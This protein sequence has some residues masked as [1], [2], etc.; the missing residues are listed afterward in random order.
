L[1]SNQSTIGIIGSGSFG[2]TMAKLLSKNVNVLLYS[3]KH[4]TIADLNAHHAHL[5]CDLSE[6]IQLTSDKEELCTKCNIIFPVVPSSMFRSMMQD[7]S[8]HLNPSHI[9]IHCTKG[10]DY[11]YK[12]AGQINRINRVSRDQVSTM[13]EV[14]REESTVLRIGCLAGP[15]LAREILQDKPAAT[16]IASEFQE[17]I[18]VGTKLLSSNQFF[19]F[20]SNDIRGAEIAGS[21]KNIIA[22]GSGLLE[23]LNL[24]KNAQAIIITRGL[25]EMIQF[26]QRFGTEGSAFLGTAGIGD[27]VATA[28]SHNSRNFTFG[29]RI[30]KGESLEDVISTS[31]EVVEGLRTLKIVKNLNE[32][33]SLRL[34]ITNM[35][36]SIF[37]EE[38]NPIRALNIL[39]KSPFKKDVVF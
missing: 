4:K 10:F 9:L 17:V 36:Y 27:L 18:D 35:L 22:L 5:K 13:S 11:R 8:K 19:V 26:G 15:N 34:P 6:D 21:F 28:T 20:G 33:Y 14:I 32:T 25:H 23:G 7:F 37:Y 24:G 30:A 38:M 3:R 31:K 2:I 29:H 39:M 12:E 16:V 1:E